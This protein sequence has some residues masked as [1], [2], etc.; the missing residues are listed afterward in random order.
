MENV[1]TVLASSGMTASWGESVKA[2]TDQGGIY[3]KAARISRTVGASGPIG[4]TSGSIDVVN[5]VYMNTVLFDNDSM[6]FGGAL[7]INTAGYWWLH[8]TAE[9]IQNGANGLR[10]TAIYEET[11]GLYLAPVTRWAGSLTTST[12]CFS[13]W[14]GYLKADAVL[15]VRVA[16]SSGASAYLHSAWWGLSLS[17]VLIGD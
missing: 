15:W 10:T 6:A 3:R 1:P 5:P 16:Q 17:A 12:Y 8:S 9:W 4:T 11:A 14:L 7:H 2:A 13:H